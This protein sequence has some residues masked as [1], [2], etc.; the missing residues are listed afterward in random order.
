LQQASLA[1]NSPSAML[2]KLARSWPWGFRGVATAAIARRSDS[3]TPPR[4]ASGST[5]AGRRN[6][7][8]RSGDL[9]R[10]GPNSFA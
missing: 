8:R 4:T 3:M 7:A 10:A 9:L 5:V 1:Q 2:V 6:S